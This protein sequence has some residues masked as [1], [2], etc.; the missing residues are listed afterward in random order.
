MD[1]LGMF[2][3]WLNTV[4]TALAMR[5]NDTEDSWSHAVK[6]AKAACA[7]IST[8]TPGASRGSAWLSSKAQEHRCRR[9]DFVRSGGTYGS[10]AGSA[11]KD[12]GGGDDVVRATLVQNSGAT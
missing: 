3:Q 5:S 7:M 12:G 1:L 8:Q 6:A 2:D 11:T 4:Q 10:V 9:H